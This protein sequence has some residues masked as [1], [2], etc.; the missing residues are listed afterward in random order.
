[1][2][3]K[4]ST[5]DDWLKIT[6]RQSEPSTEE[7]ESSQNEESQAEES[8]D[9]ENIEGSRSLKN[10]DIY[11]FD[12]KYFQSSIDLAGGKSKIRKSLPLL[13]AQPLLGSKILTPPKKRRNSSPQN[14]KEN[15]RPRSGQL[16]MSSF[17]NKKKK[18][19]TR[20][21]QLSTPNLHSKNENS[22]IHLRIEKE[23]PS[24]VDERRVNRCP[25]CDFLYNSK[26][27]NSEA[28]HK[29]VHESR[30]NAL[31]IRSGSVLGAKWVNWKS[32]SI[33]S[34]QDKHK[35]KKLE[36]FVDEIFGK[37]QEKRKRSVLVYIENEI[38]RICGILIYS[39]STETASRAILD[40]NEDEQIIREVHQDRK[41][42][43]VVIDRLWVDFSRRRNGIASELV[44]TLI[45]IEKV[46]KLDIC[47][48]DPTPDG[49]KFGI[50]YF[51]ENDLLVAQ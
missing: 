31:K 16:S 21:K 13:P 35:C 3:I 48:T 43:E 27:M 18:V 51:G 25:E 32:G 45:N 10:E 22:R 11:D 8:Q 40:E 44:N 5:L 38:K 29:S 33:Y 30:L 37:S 23:N 47:M 14:G 28:E 39:R 15:K 50:S 46:D 4:L 9:E 24:R 2:K 36:S 7:D 17:M 49:A 20:P 1:M 34:V 12:E 6:D 41:C 42:V 26:C 19:L